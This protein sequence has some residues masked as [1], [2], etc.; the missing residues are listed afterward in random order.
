MVGVKANEGVSQVST[1]HQHEPADN[2]SCVVCDRPTDT[3]VA[4]SGTA[5]STIAALTRLGVHE[6]VATMMVAGDGEVEHGVTYGFRVC[7]SCAER[8]GGDFQP[9]PI[10]G[11]VPVYELVDKPA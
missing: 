4:F 9:G 3:A 2:E 8:R 1:P 11:E 6:P 10:S 7:A 5:V